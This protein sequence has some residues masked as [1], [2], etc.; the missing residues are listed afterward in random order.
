MC[1]SLPPRFQ[2]LET[3]LLTQPRLPDLSDQLDMDSWMNVRRAHSYDLD[4]G[5]PKRADQIP[6]SDSPSVSDYF[7]TITI[8]DTDL[9]ELRRQQ[10]Q[11]HEGDKEIDR[12]NS[13]MLWPVFAPE[14]VIGGVELGG[15]LGGRWLA[16][17]VATRLA[18][19]RAAEQVAKDP[20]VVTGAAGASR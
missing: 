5:R 16:K 1:G 9:A 10:A 12:Q 4:S 17:R 20:S 8:E 15:L 7:P 3:L 6:K 2:A 14:V 18:T 13:W 19:Q 11:F